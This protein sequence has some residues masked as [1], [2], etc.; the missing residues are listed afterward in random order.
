MSGDHGEAFPRGQTRE[1]VGD[2]LRAERRR[3][4][5]QDTLIALALGLLALGLP[6][7]RLLGRGAPFVEGITPLLRGGP[8]SGMF[9]EREAF[10]SAALS[11]ALGWLV[12][13]RAAR[14]N[15]WESAAA[16][17]A[18]LIAASAP[19]VLFAA[20]TPGP[21]AAGWL[22]GCLVLA[23]LVS[24]RARPSTRGVCWLIASGLHPW[25][26]W[27]WPAWLLRELRGGQVRWCVGV[28]LVAG[29]ALLTRVGIRPGELFAGF[30]GGPGPCVAWWTLWIAGL[31]G[32]AWGLIALRR[33]PPAWLLAFALV[34][35]V[36]LSVSG[37]IGYDIP[38][39]WLAPLGWLGALELEKRGRKTGWLLAGSLACAAAALVWVRATDPERAW[40]ELAE[41]RLEPGDLVLT[42]STA[43]S[44]L[45][46]TRHGLAVGLLPARWSEG[47]A[48]QALEHAVTQARSRGQRIVLDLDSLGSEGERLCDQAT[49]VWAAQT[50]D[51]HLR[52]R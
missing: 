24:E 39:L 49:C 23:S 40:R 29:L 43:H 6:T 22:G 5:L 52:A 45:L 27:L 4:W 34:P 15:G 12:L 30:E 35:F 7:E 20:T 14:G 19:V 21:A 16:L 36:P 47:P 44:Y 46:G 2:A 8:S 3:A 10:F 33:A 31:A 25:N 51:L 48:T 41:A 32:A 38:W 17:R 26:L 18:S 1:L 28:A 11:F 13:V 42:H 37:T 9:V 50:A